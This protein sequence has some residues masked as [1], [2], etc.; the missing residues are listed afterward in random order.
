MR[1]L[2]FVTIIIST[3]KKEREIINKLYSMNK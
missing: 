2:F 3:K 1:D